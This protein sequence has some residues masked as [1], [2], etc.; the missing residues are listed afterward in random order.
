[1]MRDDLKI[2]RDMIEAAKTEIKKYVDDAL[3]AKPEE[4]PAA[5]KQEK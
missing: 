5:K 2:I 1:M 4:K 3:K